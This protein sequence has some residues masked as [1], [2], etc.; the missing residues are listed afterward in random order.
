MRIVTFLGLIVAAA[1]GFSAMMA[2][3]SWKTALVFLAIVLLCFRFGV[4]PKPFCWFPAASL[5]LVA[6]T[7]F[8]FNRFASPAQPGTLISP[9][10]YVAGAVLS[11]L[12]DYRGSQ[13]S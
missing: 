12:V 11:L 3:P 2:W 7:A 4:R 9:V 1:V 13:R 8:L 6:A 5:L 10:G